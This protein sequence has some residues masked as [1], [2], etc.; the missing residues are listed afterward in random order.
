MRYYPEYGICIAF[1]INTDI[2]IVDHS[3]PVIEDMEMR[4]AEAVVAAARQTGRGY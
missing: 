1:Q 3:E 4:L 2:G